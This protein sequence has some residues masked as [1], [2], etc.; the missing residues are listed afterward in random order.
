MSEFQNVTI[1][2]AAHIYYDGK[3]SS[4]ALTF[5]DGSHKTLGIM[6]PGTYRFSTAAA[7]IKVTGVTDYCCSYLEQSN[8]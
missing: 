6:L 8:R 5:A 1:V 3:V 4:R 7:E 2:K